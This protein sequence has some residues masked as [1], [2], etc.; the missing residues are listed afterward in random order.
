LYGL[1]FIWAIGAWL[2]ID[3]LKYRVADPY[4]PGL[5][6]TT[7][8]PILVIHHLYRTR[9]AKGLLILLGFVAIVV[10]LQ[11]LATIAYLAS[12]GQLTN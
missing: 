2:R 8:W 4:C 12:A 6:L 11:L 7:A 3:S 9:G 1:G 10:I 5:L